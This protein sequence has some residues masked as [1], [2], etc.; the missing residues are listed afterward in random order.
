MRVIENPTM[1]KENI[2]KVIK[3]ITDKRVIKLIKI[4]VVII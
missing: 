1:F 2:V 4:I 3:N